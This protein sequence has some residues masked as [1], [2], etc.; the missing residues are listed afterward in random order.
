[1]GIGFSGQQKVLMQIRPGILSDLAVGSETEM[2]FY[3]VELPN[4]LIVVLENRDA[5]PLYPDPV[6][7]SLD[8]LLRGDPIPSQR[9]QSPQLA[10]QAAFG[11]RFQAVTSPLTA[12][13]SPKYMG[14]SG[15]IP[16]IATYTLSVDT[17]F[18]RYISSPTD[19]R[20]DSSTRI[21]KA[22]TDLTS[23]LDRNH[24]DTGFGS[25]GRYALPLPIPV[26]NI[27]EYKLPAGTVI[28][29]G[30]VTPLFGQAGGGV[31]I[32]ISVDTVVTLGLTIPLPPY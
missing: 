21:L 3:I 30:T 18:L 31:E 11:S 6:F 27:I 8:D 14:T 23:H 26:M 4:G 7:Y 15:A 16:L 5:M 28:E 20:Y 17:M 13:I 19:H 25:V 32:H 24:A 22:G 9:R 10:V 2:D 12:T 29:V 1:M